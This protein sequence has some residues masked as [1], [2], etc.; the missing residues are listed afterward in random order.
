[1]KKLYTLA[2]LLC[3]VAFGQ[4]QT[5]TVTPALVVNTDLDPRNSVDVYIHFT[6]NT[7]TSM[8]LGWEQTANVYGSAWFLTVCDNGACFTLPHASETMLPFSPND[9]AFLKVTCI[10]NN[11]NG[12]G[13]VSFRVW[14][15]NQPTSEANVTFNFNAQST[16][17][18]TASQL[19]DRFAVSPM[20]A[21]EVL[22]LS[23][24]RGGLL[25]KGVVALYDLQ[26]H[27]VLTQPVSAVQ[28]ADLHVAD[29]APGI[30]LLRYDSKE[31]SM[32]QKVVVA[33]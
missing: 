32:T 18:V 33:H 8:T 2:L 15:V 17:A 29:L 25:D 22:H 11:V 23:A 6:N 28:V 16:V 27:Q 24:L 14:D 7:Q 19:S 5:F 4:A 9:S 13:T 31:G 1:M 12:T 30:Y 21:R 20:P 26:G 10:P 3:L